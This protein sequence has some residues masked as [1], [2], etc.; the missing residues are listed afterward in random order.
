MARVRTEEKR[1]EI[2]KAASE[3]FHEHGFDR[4][5]MSMIAERLGGSKAT[6]YGYFQSKEQLLAEALLYDVTDEADRLMNEFLSSD[7]LR[8]GLI[9]L[10]MAYMMRRLSAVPIANVKM[11]ATQPEGSTIGKEFFDR[12]LGPAWQ[13]LANRFQLLMDKGHLRR[14][15]PWVAAMHWKGLNEWD[16]F[17]KRLLGAIDGP[18]PKLI[19]KTSALAADAFLALYGPEKTT[20]S[21]SKAKK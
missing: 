17:E 9:K 3:L 10:G 16:M 21:K 18:D 13:R 15:D 1:R 19:E 12:V 7:D 11:V 20:E 2:V 14:C 5:S 6:L 8:D 4:T